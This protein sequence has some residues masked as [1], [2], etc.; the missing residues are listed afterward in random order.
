MPQSQWY[1]ETRSYYNWGT[2]IYSDAISG[3]DESS[4]LERWLN[5]GGAGLCLQ[6]QQTQALLRP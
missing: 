6:A 3:R 2:G 1:E 5:A 4:T